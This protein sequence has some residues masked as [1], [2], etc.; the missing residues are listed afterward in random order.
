MGKSH[1]QSKIFK[2]LTILKVIKQMKVEEIIAEL[3]K[4]KPDKTEKPVDFGIA[5]GLDIAITVILRME[6]KR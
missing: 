1:I 4:H 3:E 6:G 5:V 2:K